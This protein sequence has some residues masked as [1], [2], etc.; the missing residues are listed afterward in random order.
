MRG[1]AQYAWHV[2]LGIGYFCVVTIAAVGLNTVVQWMES[3]RLSML[4]NSFSS[5]LT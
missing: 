2:L 4:I 1:L 5:L 3:Q